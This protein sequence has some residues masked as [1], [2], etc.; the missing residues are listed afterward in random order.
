[1]TSHG[2]SR[3]RPA[4]QEAA[5]QAR[6]PAD[7][8]LVPGSRDEGEP[9]DRAGSLT[10]VEVR[11]TLGVGRSG[12]KRLTRWALLVA[13]LVA[14]GSLALVIA[15]QRAQARAPRYVTEPVRRVDL[16]VTVSATGNLQGVNTVDVGAEVTG[17]ALA[18]LV[19]YNDRV[20]VGQVLAELD[21]EQ[22][23][24]MVDEARAQVLSSQASIRTAEASLLE[25]GQARARAEES[26]KQ[27]LIAERELEAA[28]A[29]A[30]R[31][32]ATVASARA[33]AVL[34]RASL[35]CA[36]SRLGKT[37]IVAPI[38]GV[39]LSR[40][41]E[42][43]QTVTAGFQTPILFRLAEDLSQLALHVDVDEADVGRVKE[44]DEA[45]FTVDAYPGR[46]FPSRVLSLRNEP[47]TSQSV[48][49]YEAL[50]AVDNQD[51][52]LRPGMTATATIVSRTVRNAAVV[53]NAALRF[54][55]PAPPG[56]GA[57]RPAPPPGSRDKRIFVLDGGVPRAMPV[58]IGATDGVSTEILSSQPVIGTEVVVDATVG[59]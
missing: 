35:K 48:V 58:R 29:A 8:A 6:R 34:A 33:G 42:P 28:E 17:K 10:E 31:A 15:R 22:L 53:P 55:P 16:R 41:I 9:A 59:R 24:A 27:G 38:R 51:L 52:A 45:S 26:M 25:A 39:V 20:E 13:A 1:M 54:V 2:E 43:G 4:G 40:S 46:T 57:A 44:K 49:S 23:R 5:G 11:R 47:K 37:Q 7:R 14:L 21:P 3:P 36:R 30:A 12:R 18:V 56:A 50:L 32:E 19:D